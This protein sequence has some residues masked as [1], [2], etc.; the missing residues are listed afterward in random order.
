MQIE[1]EANILELYSA[2]C[3]L[4]SNQVQIAEQTAPHHRLFLSLMYDIA[5]RYGMIFS[6]GYSMYK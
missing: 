5:I 4:W 1:C 6:Y 2:N 3:L